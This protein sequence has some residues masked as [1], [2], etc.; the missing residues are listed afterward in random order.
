MNRIQATSPFL[1]SEMNI[2]GCQHQSC[3]HPLSWESSAGPRSSTMT[4]WHCTTSHHTEGIFFT[5]LHLS[6][7][8]I[9]SGF[10][11]SITSTTIYKKKE[12][13]RAH[14]L[15]I[16]GHCPDFSGSNLH[17]WWW[18][19][20]TCTSLN[21]KN[22][23]K[24]PEID[25]THVMLQRE[26]HHLPWGQGCFAQGNGLWPQQWGRQC[27]E[28]RQS[29]DLQNQVHKRLVML[30]SINTHHWWEEFHKRPW[31][32]LTESRQYVCMYVCTYWISSNGSCTN[33][34]LCNT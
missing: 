20:H 10:T 12:E 5:W 24:Q 34:G 6:I 8:R 19:L 16:L 33:L 13:W 30:H 23:D 29:S 21:Q 1:S 15:S 14:L 22:L 25:S 7:I 9:I 3:F 17:M 11:W 32:C 27:S 26:E 31:Q 4:Q 2:P 28:H 18:K